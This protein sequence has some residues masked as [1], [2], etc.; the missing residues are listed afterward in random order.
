MRAERPAARR[1]ARQPRRG[2][3]RGA[4]RH[5]RGRGGAPRPQAGQRHARRRPAGGHRLRHRAHPRRDQADQDRPG[6]GHPR[7]PRARGHR[8]RPVERRVGR[9]LVG[10]HGRLRRHRPPAVRQRRPTRRSSSAC[11]RARRSST[12]CRRTCCRSSPRRCPPTRGPGR[13]RAG[14]P[15]SSACRGRRVDAAARGGGDPRGA[16]AVDPAPD[17]RRLRLRRR[18]QRR[19]VRRRS[20]PGR[21]PV[22]GAGGAGRGRPAAARRARRWRP[23]P[24]GRSH[25][26]RPQAPGGT[27]QGSRTGSRRGSACSA[28]PP[29]SPRWRSACC[30][31]SRA[32][33]SS[34]AVIT[35]LRAADRAQHALTER[36]SRRGARPS[37]IAIVIVTA[38]WTVVR[39]ALTTVLLAPLALLVALP[40]ARGVGRPRPGR[41]RCP[42]RAAGRRAPRSPSTASGPAR[43]RRGG[44]CGG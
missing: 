42:A 8:G 25:R 24:S 27:R 41:G 9:A 11:S 22:A 14:W 20:G 44:S 17:L 6:D 31:L 1:G 34:L 13:P 30:S 33:R 39:A 26:R 16:P 18:S 29:G 32:R 38:P 43:A 15:D 21:V 4:R 3:R 19:R 28:W 23:R 37:D 36:R 7:V 5:P 10:R 40:A 35:L 2:A 12:G